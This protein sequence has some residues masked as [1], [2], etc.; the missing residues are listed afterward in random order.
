M[1]V[2]D[3]LSVDKLEIALMKIIM[4]KEEK[5]EK[6]RRRYIISLLLITVYRFENYCFMLRSSY[7]NSIMNPF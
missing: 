7:L 6:V 5:D 1:F 4:G 2:Q 3:V